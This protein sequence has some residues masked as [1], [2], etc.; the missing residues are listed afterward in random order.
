MGESLDTALGMLGLS[1]NDS[2]QLNN[3]NKK[4]K[5]ELSMTTHSNQIEENIL[6]GTYDA[7]DEHSLLMAPTE[8]TLAG[9]KHIVS[10]YRVESE[11][12]NGVKYKLEDVLHPGSARVVYVSTH[13]IRRIC[14]ENKVLLRTE[15]S[16]GNRFERIALLLDLESAFDGKI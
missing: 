12:N 9:K 6:N 16:K 11:A 1:N 15:S 3:I 7:G 8:I 2:G 10:V 13:D 14:N 5:M 4:P